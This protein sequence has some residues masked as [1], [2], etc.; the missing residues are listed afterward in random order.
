MADAYEPYHI[1]QQS[2][3][4]K[5]RIPS[6]DSHFH[7]NH[8]PPPSSSGGGLFPFTDSDYLAAGGFHSNNN[9]NH[10]S[11]PSHSNFMGFLGGPSSSS[12]AAVTVAGDPSFNAELSSG[13]V[14][15]FRP[16]PLSLSLSS[17]PRLAYDLVVPGVA[18]FGFC[19]SASEAAAA[20][21]TVASRSSGPLGPCTGYASIL[22]GSRFLKPA[23]MLLDEFCN[24][25]LGVYTDKVMDDEDD[26][27]LLFDPT[28]ETLC[29]V[30][31][32]HGKKKSKLISMLDEVYKR[33]K[34]YYEQL[35]AVMGS[36]E[37]VAGL[38]HAAPYASLTLK[39]L[40]KHFKCLKTAITDQL[41][42]STNNKR[43]QQCG[44]VMDS[45]N[46]TDSLR[47]GGSDSGRGLCSA[48]QRHGFPDHHA[49]VWRPHRGLPE[50][51]VAVLRAW[52]FDHFLH[53]YPTDTDKLVLA[54]HTGLSR[55]QVSNWFINA[56]V[57]VWKPMVEEIHLLETRQSQRSSS[58]SWRDERSTAD[59]PDNNNDNPSSSS[60]QQRANNNSSPARR[61]RNHD[62]H[63]P[64]SNNNNNFM[65]A[66]S[67]GSGGG[68]VSFS[69]GI[70]SSN[71]PGISSST[72][73]G[74]SLTLGLHHQIGLSE[75]FPMTTAQRLGLD[76][77]SSGG[78]GG[79]Y[80]RQNRQFGRDF[81]GG[82]NHQFLHDFVG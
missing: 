11:N 41:Q 46:K 9:S 27:S 52:L 44:H 51:A 43:Q 31:G 32:E 60:A 35:Q 40:S 1:L 18:S 22:K 80:D 69:Y 19:R 23:Q 5:L 49:P 78:G 50:R 53:P 79:G 47:F 16:E 34:Q 30:S 14:L 28:V 63:G 66:G 68:A 33:Y 72:N 8:P 71:I 36:F 3:R 61:V 6:L 24:V 58:S 13:D 73:G 55:N 67:G 21:V 54:K 39:A 56:R 2:R 26:S 42:F 20:A 59:F 77:G 48:G 82:S 62:V 75:P 45:D 29:G 7:F 64:N 37:C 57:R 65:N 76:G 38:G 12:S 10:I 70:A 74:V 15:V 81:I 25:A 4:D 17:H